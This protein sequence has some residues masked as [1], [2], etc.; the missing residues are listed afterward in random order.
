MNHLPFPLSFSL[1]FPLPTSLTRPLLRLALAAATCAGALPAMAEEVVVYSARN[2][3]L[4][5]PLLDAYTKQTGV[6][7]K[8]ITDKE[9]PLM[10]R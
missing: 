5:K 9:G 3:Q 7:V 10:E 6:A 2:E 4:L 1:P 8:F